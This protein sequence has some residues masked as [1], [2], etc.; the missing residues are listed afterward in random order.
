MRE[1]KAPNERSGKVSQDWAFSTSLWAGHTGITPALVWDG[2]THG[3]FTARLS[4]LVPCAQ[5]LI[6]VTHSAMP[7]TA[8]VSNSQ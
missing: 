1:D 2:C 4:I 5:T 3:A 7:Q 6:I 8:Q